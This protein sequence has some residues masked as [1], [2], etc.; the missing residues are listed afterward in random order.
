MGYLLC[1]CERSTTDSER[2]DLA[3]SIVKLEYKIRMYSCTLAY[4]VTPPTESWCGAKEAPAARWHPTCHD[5]DSFGY[6]VGS[7][8]PFRADGLPRQLS[9]SIQM[10]RER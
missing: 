7:T 5:L 8:R 1:N 6:S 4:I 10:P 9:Q 2:H 3:N